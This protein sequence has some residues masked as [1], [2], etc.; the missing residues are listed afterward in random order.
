MTTIALHPAELRMRG[1]E[2]L[3]K[4]LGWVNAV[5]FIQQYEPSRFN[6]TQE[7]DELL[8]EWDAAELIRQMKAAAKR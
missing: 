4:A 2:A 8:P 6:Y 3:V 1:F 5:R 7:R